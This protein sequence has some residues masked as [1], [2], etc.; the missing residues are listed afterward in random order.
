VKNKEIKRD[1]LVEIAEYVN[2]PVGQKIFT[3][4]L[5]PDIVEMVRVNVFRALPPPTDDYDPEEDEPAMEPSWP[6][7]QVHYCFY[8]Y[9]SSFGTFSSL[10]N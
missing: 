9:R 4:A 6:H 8:L 5:M 10:I 7:L 2:T 1:T 3:E